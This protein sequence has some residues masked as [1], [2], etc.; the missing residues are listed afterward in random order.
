[1]N[2]IKLL[3]GKVVKT[4]LPVLS[5]PPGPDTPFCK[6]LLLPPGELAQFHDSAEGFR[7]GAVIELRPNALRGNHYHQQKEETVYLF[8]GEMRVVVEDVQTG[9]Q[10]SVILKTGDQ[11][12]IPPGVAH[13]L[14]PLTGGLAVETSPARFNPADTFKRV[15]V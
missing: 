13:V 14:V 2:E 6:R 15:L 7:F 11:I 10:E 1:M 4:S 9:A 3:G 5:C 8:S 12:T